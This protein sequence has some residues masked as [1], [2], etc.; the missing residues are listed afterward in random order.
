MAVLEVNGV[1][2]SFG[3][4][5]VLK[6]A[7][8]KVEE[9]ELVTIIGAS[10]AGKSTLL[11]IIGTLD[12]SNAGSVSILGTDTSV[13]KGNKL[14]DFRNKNIGFVF[15]FHNLLPEFSALENIMLPGFIGKKNKKEVKERAEMLLNEFGLFE[16]AN[17]R[18]SQL[19]G[20]E[21]QRIAVA[22]S[23]INEPAIVFAD[24]PSGNLDEKNAAHLHELFLKLT[25]DFNYTFLAVTHN[26]EFS[27]MAHRRLILKDGVIITE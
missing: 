17:N 10:G 23:L 16:K 2:K 22:R 6:G 26:T 1:K 15:Q 3:K 5:E 12:N 21:Q 27:S 9:K 19:S 20:G 8:L 4:S 14:A 11:H 18:P 13:L 25:E 24:E 7:S